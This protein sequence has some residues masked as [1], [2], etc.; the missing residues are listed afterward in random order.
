[1]RWKNSY[2]MFKKV[3]E[4]EREYSENSIF[5]YKILESD[6]FWVKKTKI[7]TGHNHQN[8]W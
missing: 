2:Y 3:K 6:Q 1:M 5:E 4:P 7:K 8:K